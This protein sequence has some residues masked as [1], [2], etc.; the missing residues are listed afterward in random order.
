MSTLY[1]T[2]KT[3]SVR[4]ENQ[5]LIIVSEDAAQQ[6]CSTRILLRDV[7][8]VVVSGSPNITVPVL[9]TFCRA[10]IPLAFVSSHGRWVGELSG[11]I[12]NNAERRIAQYRASIFGESA[13]MRFART[14]VSTKIF[15][16]R[17]VLRR[18]ANRHALRNVCGNALT[19]LKAL[20]GLSAESSS[21]D[22]LR[23]I[24]GLAAAE[25]F[26]ALAQFFPADVP[27]EERSR[28]PP[29][30]A[31]N[32]LLSFSYAIVLSEIEF[33][34]RLHGLDPA[35]GFLHSGEPGRASL[36][37]DLLEPF[38]PAIDS[39]A[40]SLLNRKILTCK[41]FWFSNE[42]GGVYLDKNSHPTFF[43]H[44]E[45]SM[46]RRFIFGE[47]DAHV[48]FRQLLDWQVCRYLKSLT[49][50][51]IAPEFFKFPQ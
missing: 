27:F 38:R 34:I 2:I 16:Q 5:A 31:A 26:R 10:R 8:R 41:D 19:K 51:N 24:E 32:A 36:A 12:S 20:R 45:K 35:I 29:K 44:Y 46:T 30:N 22:M 28:R 33:A 21:L 4:L 40:L 15:N 25:Y 3:H 7:S 9:K 47:N 11:A 48:N 23:G 50:E 1:L 17:H 49:D 43:R 18:L 14:A 42:D 37:L 13:L 6:T 39:F